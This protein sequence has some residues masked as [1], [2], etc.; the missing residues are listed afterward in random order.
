MRSLVLVALGAST[1][2]MVVPAAA[3]IPVAASA[4]ACGQQHIYRITG[5]INASGISC[6]KA[7]AVFRAVERAHLPP[8]VASPPYL[9]YSRSYSVATPSGRFSCRREPHGLG[10]SEHNIRCRRGSTRV[11][12]Y[13]VHD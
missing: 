10:G 11:D 13:T 1:A 7:Q 9:H 8:D 6:S 2:L 5:S 12:W 4:R 3:S